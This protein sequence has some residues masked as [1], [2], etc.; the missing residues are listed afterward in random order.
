MN[1]Y[2]SN[3]VII[4]H[5]GESKILNFK[6]GLNIITG[7]SKTGK[8][9]L[10]E[11]V[12]F[13]LF[14]K[15]STIPVGKV[16]DFTKLFCCVFDHDEKKIIIARLNKE[17]TKCYFSIAYDTDFDIEERINDS[18]FS[19]MRPRTRQEVQQDFE[20]HL[21][22]SV[23]DTSEDNS[24]DSDI[25]KGKVSIRNAT[26]LFFQH[27]NLIANKHGLFYRFD[28]FIKSRAVIN[29]FPIF[30]G[31][32]DSRYYRLKKRIE[33]L[34]KQIKI[35]EKEEK[36][37][38][39]DIQSQ[40]QKLLVPIKQYYNVINI[41]FLEDDATLSKLKHIA[42]NLPVV[43]I[44]AEQNIDFNKQLWN[45]ENKKEKELTSLY[46]C[47]QLISLIESNEEESADYGRSMSRLAE[48]SSDTSIIDKTIH[49]PLCSSTVSSV[50][51]KLEGVK[52]S[53]E[54]LFKELSKVESYKQDS[55]GS[56]NTLLLKRD[57]QKQSISTIDGEIRQLK[58]LYN[59]KNNLSLRDE[60]N[61]IR[62]RLENTLEFLLDS[63][64]P[65]KPSTYLSELKDELELC[66]KQIKG[67]GLEHKFSEANAIINKTMNE[68]KESLDFEDDLRNG[69]MR[70]KVEDFS[71]SYFMNNQEILLSEMGS[72]ANWLACHLAVFL[73]I[74][75]LTA[76]SKSVIPAML[77][78][79]QPSQ[80]YFPKVT[81]RFSSSNKQELINEEEVDENIK[82]V[83]NIFKVIEKFL[84][85]LQED[86]NI[87]FKPQ[88]IVLE[89]ADEPEFDKYIRYRWSANG[90]KLI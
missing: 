50:N 21:G 67:Y 70:F 90:K 62:G 61:N 75:K 10:I 13:C 81:R 15:R 41:K 60:L 56:L 52:H 72:G 88:V 22:L 65:Y 76:I 80:V 48:L 49:C 47:N 53:R 44:N 83:I 77:F 58:K 43:P 37:N 17:P 46:E 54:M 78:L 35:I 2:L 68:L 84:N 36:Q 51:S 55:S 12:D 34:D 25:N 39:F 16:T 11:I 28:S 87:G 79:D 8:S 27:Q 89:H 5:N 14:S 9:A 59:I 20:E 45:L 7:D 64:K 86:K 69:E 32:V 73:S 57:K 6:Q 33:V 18:F 85:N 82:Q 19:A 40:R 3:I 26:S 4:G 38:Q 63:Q 23:E 74:L 31:W 42:T 30:M 29:Q 66:N 71:F 1:A 24:D